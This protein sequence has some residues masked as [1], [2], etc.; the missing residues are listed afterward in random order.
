MSLLPT[1]A[2]L[3]QRLPRFLR[4]HKLMKGWMALTGESPVQLVRV[5]DD[6]RAFADMSDGFLRLIPIEGGYD[7]D[8]FV[9]ADRL[10]EE[11]GTFFDVGAN[12]GLLSIGL[13]GRHGAAIDFHL[14]EPNPRLVDAIA[15]SQQLYPAMRAAINRVAVADAPGEVRFSINDGQSGVSHISTGDEA[16]G[17][18]VPA[19]TLD[20]YLAET[21][22]RQVDMLKLDVE[23]FELAALRGA[24][25]GL[26][27]RRIRTVYFEYFEK[28]LVRVAPPEELIAFLTAHGFVTCFCRACDFAGRAAPS[29][30]IA[31]GHAGHGLPL[32]PVE[33]F[34]RPPMTDLLAIPAEHL[35]AL[36]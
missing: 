5:R 11:G 34:N 15:R 2:E 3:T 36:A 25:E 6:I 1:A 16:D 20:G 23:G 35:A 18:A 24:A 7:D 4:R 33:G 27:S 21:G 13:A 19:I 10:L 30:T 32:L 12:F 9:V 8:F 28:Y 22:I 17:V 14:F 31:R 29:H 26:R